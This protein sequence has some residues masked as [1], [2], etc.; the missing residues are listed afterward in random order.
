MQV[1]TL[2]G[3]LGAGALGVALLLGGCATAVVDPGQHVPAPEGTVFTYHRVSSGSLG[4]FDGPVPWTLR[5]GPWQGREALISSSQLGA[6]VFDLET[7]LQL[8]TLDSQGRP[9]MVFEPPLGFRYPLQVGNAWTDQHTVTLPQRSATRPLT[10]NYKIEAYEDVTVPAGSF[11][12]FRVY[13]TDS[14]GEVTTIWTAPSL[15][16]NVIKR[17]QDRPAS[18]PQGAGHLQGELISVQKP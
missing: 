6:T 15:S 9:A 7:G 17:I 1:T 2:K 10:V 16:L 5:K 3:R 14:T 4:N 18:H 13:A 8:G 12:A 11:K